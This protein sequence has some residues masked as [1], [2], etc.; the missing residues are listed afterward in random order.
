VVCVMW[1][2][3]LNE[4]CLPLGSNLFRTQNMPLTMISHRNTICLQRPLVQIALNKVWA[5]S[6][7]WTI[8]SL[9]N[10]KQHH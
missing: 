2:S 6:P 1:P 10:A 5:L 8:L 4:H 7:N 9:S 3:R